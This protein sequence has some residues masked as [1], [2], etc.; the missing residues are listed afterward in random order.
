MKEQN[1]LDHLVGVFG[2]PV[3]ENPGV[4]IQDAA[5]EAMGLERWHFL[6]I[7]VDKDQLGNAI[8]GLKAFKMRGINCTIPHKIEVMKYLDEI[9][10]S[11]KLIGAVNMIVNDNGHLFGENTDGKGFMMSLESNGVDVKG[12]K[13]VVFGAGGAARAICVEI[14]LAGVADITIVNRA[15]D[16]ALGDS[17]MEILRQTPRRKSVMLIGTELIRSLRAQILWSTL[18]LW[19]S[20]RMWTPYP[21]WISTASPKT[22]SSK[23]SSPTRRRPPSSGSCAAAGSPAPPAPACSSTRLP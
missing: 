15:Q 20:I 7:D 17:L 21:M 23:M 3:A 22:C 4:V 12:K 11:A 16:R 8:A 13:V 10:E 14:G 9:S 5:F 1:Y 19:A 6:T 18:L 2:Q